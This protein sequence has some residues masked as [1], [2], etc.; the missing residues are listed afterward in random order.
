MHK[1]LFPREGFCADV[2]LKLIRATAL[3]PSLLLPLVL[4]ARFTKK[5]QDL[6]ILHPTVFSRLQSLLYFAVARS[7]SSWYSDKVR[8]NWTKDK[9]DWSKEIV[10][11]TGGAGGIGG[12]IV[13]LFEEMDVTV[14]VLD[15]Q[16]MSFA[17]CKSIYTTVSQYSTVS[18]YANHLQ[19]PKS[20]T[21]NAI[22]ALLKSSPPSQPASPAKSVTPPSSSTMPASPE[23]RRSSMP[24]QATSASPSTLTLWPPSGSP[25]RSSRT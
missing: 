13:K 12:S 7:L 3:N 6:S 16:P 17:T 1:G 25:R 10:L 21:T 22:S 20:I 19:P 8:N 9:Y 5:G 4:L 23:A 14:V 24:R 18:A 11:V 15:I 2:I